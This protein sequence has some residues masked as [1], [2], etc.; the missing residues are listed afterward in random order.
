VLSWS[1][2]ER[3]GAKDVE[4]EEFWASIPSSLRDDSVK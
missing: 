4:G 1:L 3:S 2:G